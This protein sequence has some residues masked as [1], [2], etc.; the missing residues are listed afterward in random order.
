MH[1]IDVLHAFD[2]INR[3]K[4]LLRMRKRRY[5]VGE[6]AAE[7]KI[8]KAAVSQHLNE[9]RIARLVKV[10]FRHQKQRWYALTPEGF[11]ELRDS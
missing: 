10:N 6:L 4:I 3:H 11:D 9:L 2:N 1:V 5:S 7:L 8:S